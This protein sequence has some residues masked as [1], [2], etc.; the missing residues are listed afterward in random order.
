MREVGIFGCDL[1]AF[2]RDRTL[3]WDDLEMLVVAVK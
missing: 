2:S 3:G 1:G